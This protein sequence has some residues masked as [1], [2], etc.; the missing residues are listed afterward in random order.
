MT[1][2][3]WQREDARAL[4]VFLNGE[5]IPTHDRD[6]NPIEG[7]SFL[8]LFNAHHEPVPFTIAPELGDKWTVE[9]ATAGS[10]EIDPVEARAVVVLRQG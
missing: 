6:G 7:N 2:A 8:I 5:E 1:E 4:G 10:G 9:L 3:D